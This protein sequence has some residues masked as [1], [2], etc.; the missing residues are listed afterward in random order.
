METS[1]KFRERLQLQPDFSFKCS[2]SIFKLSLYTMMYRH[3][4]KWAFKGNIF[5][6]FPLP[7]TNIRAFA[8]THKKVKI[9]FN[10][11]QFCFNFFVVSLV[12]LWHIKE[13]AFCDGNL[14]LPSLIKVAAHLPLNWSSD[15]VITA[16]ERFPRGISLKTVMIATLS[17]SVNF[18]FESVVNTSYK[19]MLIRTKLHRP[20]SGESSRCARKLISWSIKHWRLAQFAS[21]F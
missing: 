18:N 10:A 16:F 11:N 14:L 19:T 1:G 13:F 17:T 2:G 7:F 6:T 5:Q 12:S 20:G 4:F 3:Q 21:L 8:A 9:Q 15:D